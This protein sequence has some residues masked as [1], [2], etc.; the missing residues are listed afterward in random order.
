M[1]IG[2][3]CRIEGSNRGDETESNSVRSLGETYISGTIGEEVAC[4]SIPGLAMLGIW[5][6]GS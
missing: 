5:V 1:P 3:L 6:T 4:E 2:T